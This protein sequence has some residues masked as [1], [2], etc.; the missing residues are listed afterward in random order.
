M[1]M[2]E[3][4]R[5][6][7]IIAHCE[8][9]MELCFGLGKFVRRFIGLS[10]FGAMVLLFAGPILAILIP[11]T[12][13]AAVGFLLWFP[14]QAVVLGRRGVWQRV[15]ERK[16]RYR[17][18]LRSRVAIVRGRCKFAAER[19][20]NL[21]DR[22][23]HRARQMSLEMMCGALVGILLAL[24]TEATEPE[25]GLAALVG[26]AAGATVVLSRWGGSVEEYKTV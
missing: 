1:T 10:I 19:I 5:T 17:E 23:L 14:V 4:R 24:A 13:C 18:L 16:C 15:H 22:W 25:I 9:A 6:K 2:A 3:E 11:L 7:R 12:A 26:S 21:V 20:S 8:V